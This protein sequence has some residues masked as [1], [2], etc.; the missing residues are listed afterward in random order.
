[1]SREVSMRKTV[2]VFV[3]LFG[4]SMAIAASLMMAA[5]AA[6]AVETN[7]A[8]PFNGQVW[9]PC[10][11]AGAGE[12]VDLT[13]PLHVLMTVTSDAAGGVHITVH[14]QP[15]GIT[16]IGETTGDSYQ[17][18]GVTRTDLNATVGQT[19]TFVNNFRI[20]GHGPGNNFQVHQMLHIIISADG[21]ATVVADHVAIDCS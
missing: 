4:V 21:T 19:I 2:G 18:T 16:G 9:V 11:A 20:I 6:A 1:M 12:V 8:I 17:G 13:G 7:T 15:M 14:S 5:P 3:S 10:A